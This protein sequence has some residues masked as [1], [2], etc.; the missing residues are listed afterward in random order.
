MRGVLRESI[1]LM[2][3][4]MSRPLPAALALVALAGFGAVAPAEANFW[5]FRNPTAVFAGLDKI[6]GRIIAFEAAV[7][8]TVQFGSLQLTARVCWSR[9]V[10]ANP[11]TSSVIEVD[12]V[13]ADNQYRRI[14][15][16]W[17]I[18][19]SPGLNAV[20]HPV[21]DVWLTDCKGATEKDRVALE[22]DLDESTPPPQAVEL[23]R[24]TPA[25]PVQP[26]Q[27]RPV[28]A[29]SAP[30]RLPGG[31]GSPPADV[32]PAPAPQQRF[33]PTNQPPSRGGYDPAGANPNR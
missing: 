10:D 4:T 30:L 28:P 8:E 9:S 33:F 17:M 19:Q 27:N 21:Y 26:V 16:G 18:A 32:R 7:D 14:F 29:G 1:P 20:E 15:S 12:E 31:P 22:S 25:R 13:G 3:L 6:T 5:K 23:R 11:R 2:P 24:N